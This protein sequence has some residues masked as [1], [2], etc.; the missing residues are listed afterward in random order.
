MSCHHF[1]DPNGIPTSLTV[2]VYVSLVLGILYSFTN[3]ALSLGSKQFVAIYVPCYWR[4][5]KIY[6][7]RTGIMEL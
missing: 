2:F 7:Q 6:Y 5:W 4:F 3:A 1:V